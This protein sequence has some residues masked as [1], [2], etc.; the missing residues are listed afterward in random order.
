MEL[1]A[2]KVR[3]CARKGGIT[4]GPIKVQVR[5]QGDEIDTVKVLKYT[6]DH[7]SVACIDGAIRDADLPSGGRPVETFT[8]PE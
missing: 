7:P 8:F 4:G 6:K 3:A 2:S 5:R 1:L